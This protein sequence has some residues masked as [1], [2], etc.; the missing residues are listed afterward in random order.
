MTNCKIEH[1]PRHYKNIIISF[2]SLLHILKEHAN[3]PGDARILCIDHDFLDASILIES[4][5]YA[6]CVG[7]ITSYKLGDPDLEGDDIV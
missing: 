4:S 7:L 1:M 3:L 2:D 5:K 6:P